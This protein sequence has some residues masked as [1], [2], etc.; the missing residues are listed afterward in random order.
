MPCRRPASPT[1]CCRSRRS[2]RPRST[3]SSIGSASKTA[4]SETIADRPL[5]VRGYMWLDGSRSRAWRDIVTHSLTH[6]AIRS[7]VELCFSDAIWLATTAGT[8][9]CCKR[10]TGR[11]HTRATLGPPAERAARSTRGSSKASAS[12]RLRAGRCHRTPAPAP[13]DTG[14]PPPDTGHAG[15]DDKNFTQQVNINRRHAGRPAGDRQR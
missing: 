5:L 14:S 1:F 15:P 6:H 3:S 7:T 8:R 2:R 12:S 11:P 9:P 10:T 4:G 13:D